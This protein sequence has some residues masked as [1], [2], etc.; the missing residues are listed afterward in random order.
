MV[1]FNA[2]LTFEEAKALFT[3]KGTTTFPNTPHNRSMMAKVVDEHLKS[4]RNK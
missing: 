1:T 2:T 3:F 4:L